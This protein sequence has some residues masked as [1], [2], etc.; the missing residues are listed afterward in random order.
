MNEE[1]TQEEID[2]QEEEMEEPTVISHKDVSEGFLARAKDDRDVVC[3]ISGYEGDG[4]ST[5]AVHHT[6]DINRLRGMTD[7]EILERFDDYMLYS[8]N[9]EITA[10]KVMKPDKY[11]PI[12]S[13]EATKALYK[14]NWASEGQKYLNMLYQL[15][16]KENKVNLFCIPR[17][18]DL[19]EY[20]RNHR[21]LFWIFIVERGTAV[22]MQKDW[23]PFTTDPWH[24]KENEKILKESMRRKKII[25]LSPNEKIALLQKTQ[26]FVAVFHYDDLEK[27]FKKK[28]LE[29]KNKHGYDEMS[30][31]AD[32][33][34]KLLDKYKEG[35]RKS[36]LALREK[37][38][39][40]MD[41]GKIIGVTDR[42]V[43]RY[44]EDK[45]TDKVKDT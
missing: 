16:R 27:P 7:E 37:G 13:D 44:M 14:L 17:F 9:K 22:L 34:G 32:V 21:V 24:L 15:C 43:R 30:Q 11:A 25:D 35:L 4:K 26:N 3:A 23:N 36:V 10:E 38:L 29:G 5:L 31:T 1:I 18:T 20:F 2:A 28:Y 45:D 19:N 8:P 39:T 33:G 41:I 40:V 12:N 6:I 42:T